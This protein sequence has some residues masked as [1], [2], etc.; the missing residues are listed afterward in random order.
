MASRAL[1]LD[2]DNTLYS[3]V[4][5]FLPSF[6]AVVH[7]LSAMLGADE[8][9][10]LLDFRNVYQ[11]HGSV[12]YPRA[13]REL[14]IWARLG[15]SEEDRDKTAALLE[16]IFSINYKKNLKLYPNVRRVLEWAM[17][18]DIVV[19]GLSDALERWVCYRLRMLGIERYFSGLYTWGQESWFEERRPHKSCIKNR[20]QL[21]TEEL[22]P[23]REVVDRVL[24]DFSMPSARAYMVGDSVSKDIV[25]AQAAGVTDV[26]ARYGTT[27]KHENLSTLRAI[28]PWTEENKSGEDIA[29]AVVVPSHTIDDFGELIDIIGSSQPTL[30]D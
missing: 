30:F 18:E 19:I 15:F 9:Q 21:A 17:S 7:R 25:A 23:N 1:I 4:D 2:I 3:W 27:P 10:L 29:R 8:N 6:R 22:K 11:R 5:A 24:A 26:W 13:T 28:T 16:K 14:A 12:E 20:V